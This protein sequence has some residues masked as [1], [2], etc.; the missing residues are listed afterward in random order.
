MMSN[1]SILVVKCIVKLSYIMW[2]FRTMVKFSFQWTEC[3]YLAF[4]IN[5]LVSSTSAIVSNSKT[6][7]AA[8]AWLVWLTA[9][10]LMI[11][12]IYTKEKSEHA[13][14]H[15]WQRFEVDIAIPKDSW[16]ESVPEIYQI[17]NCH[18]YILTLH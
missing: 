7:V 3:A 2:Y 8:T 11:F 5:S 9:A 16:Y 14:H 1:N 17:P 4:L 10:F 12:N 18:I 6:R 13:R 15:E